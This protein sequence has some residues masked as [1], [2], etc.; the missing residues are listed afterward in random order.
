MNSPHLA[1]QGAATARERRS[2]ETTTRARLLCKIVEPQ[3]S[4]K[5]KP[6]P[7]SHTF[8]LRPKPLSSEARRAE[9]DQ[10]A[11]QNSKIKNPVAPF[12]ISHLPFPIPN[13]AFCT[14]HSHASSPCPLRVLCGDSAS[15]EY[16]FSDGPNS[17]L[18]AFGRPKLASGRP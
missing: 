5:D 13:S 8:R 3:A 18:A 2:S 15:P 9:E 1:P 4:G 7:A 14:P 10:I 12:A 11:N 17:P 16:R 6:R